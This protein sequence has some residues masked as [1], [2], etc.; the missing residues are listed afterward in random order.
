MQGIRHQRQML[1]LKHTGQLGNVLV[2]QFESL[3]GK[4]TCQQ[5]TVM[6]QIRSE[7]T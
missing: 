2:S 7:G 6:P 3:P 1:S 5:D 4:L